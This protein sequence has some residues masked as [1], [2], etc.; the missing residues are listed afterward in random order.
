MLY[1]RNTSALFT[2]VTCYLWCTATSKPR[3]LQKYYFFPLNVVVVI[4][5]K[6]STQNIFSA[7]LIVME[8]MNNG[9]K[10]KNLFSVR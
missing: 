4:P 7:A 1:G 9:F 3:L 6:F 5:P 10:T 8:I 2:T